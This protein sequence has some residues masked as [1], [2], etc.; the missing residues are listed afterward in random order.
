MSSP[1]AVSNITFTRAIYVFDVLCFYISKFF[2]S[3]HL[4]R[5]QVHG[6]LLDHDMLRKYTVL[7]NS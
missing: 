1:Y 6:L 3:I 2:L 5:S 7:L 4:Y